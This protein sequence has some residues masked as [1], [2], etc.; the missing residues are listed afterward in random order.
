MRPDNWMLGP[1]RKD[2]QALGPPPPP[3]VG[4]AQTLT[5]TP[6]LDDLGPVGGQRIYLKTIPSS[7]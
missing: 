4:G 3:P 2:A 5:P 1:S 6:T 7:L